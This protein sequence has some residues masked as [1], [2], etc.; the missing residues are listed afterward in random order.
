MLNK[1]TPTIQERLLEGNMTRLVGRLSSRKIM[2]VASS[3]TP[4]RENRSRSAVHLHRHSFPTLQITRRRHRD[5]R[6]TNCSRR[7]EG[8]FRKESELKSGMCQLVLMSKHACV[9][10]CRVPRK[11][12]PKT[13]RWPRAV[14]A[15][16][17]RIEERSMPFASPACAPKCELRG[18]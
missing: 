16:K 7:H 11:K 1:V 15:R 2:K 3:G 17:R 12:Q 4:I 5:Y 6:H 18:W 14:L 10:C 9:V 13:N 8:L